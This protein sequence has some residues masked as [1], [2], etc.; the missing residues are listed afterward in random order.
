M[1]LHQHCI[2]RSVRLFM[3]VVVVVVVVLIFY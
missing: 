1:Q 2:V 3:L